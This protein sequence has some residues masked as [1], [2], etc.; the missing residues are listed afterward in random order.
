MPPY[1]WIGLESVFWVLFG[2]LIVTLAIILAR[3]SLTY[4]FTFRKRT[5]DELEAET[6]HFAN[7]VSEQ[8]R[9]MPMFIWLVTVGYF[10]WAIAYVLFSG[11]FGL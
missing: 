7:A 10:I 9:P 5:D 4:S 8:N 3:A 11:A 1:S 6:H 2:G